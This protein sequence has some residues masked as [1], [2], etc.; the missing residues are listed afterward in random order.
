MNLEPIEVQAIRP[1]DIAL[2]Q[3]QVLPSASPKSHPIANAD[4]GDE[5]RKG[6]PLAILRNDRP[7]SRLTGAVAA[8]GRG[9]LPHLSSCAAIVP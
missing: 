8:P 4:S 5:D 9:V 3:Q 6:E 7:V 2:P 1:N